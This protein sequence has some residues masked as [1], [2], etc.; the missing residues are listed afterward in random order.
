MTNQKIFE[1]SDSYFF[2]IPFRILLISAILFWIFMYC[3]GFNN[4]TTRS[5]NRRA[6]NAEIKSNI[7][8][9]QFALERYSEEH[10]NQY[11]SDINVLL[12]RYLLRLP[13]NAYVNF[14]NP[15]NKRQMRNISFGTEECYGDFTYIP[16]EVDG[17]IESYYLIGYG[18]PDDPGHDFDGDDVPDY[19]LTVAIGQNNYPLKSLVELLKKEDGV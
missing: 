15:D 18:K 12:D 8:S 3:W 10:D 2:K 19:V 5:H 6:I 13:E 1:S 11:P 16:C 17:R 9:I 4:L 7:H 14:K